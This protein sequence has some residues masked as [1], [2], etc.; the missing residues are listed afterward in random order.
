MPV[1]WWSNFH[2]V[3]FYWLIP[4][5]IRKLLKISSIW[6]AKVLLNSEDQGAKAGTKF[7][8]FRTSTQISLSE[9]FQGVARE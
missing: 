6:A 5:K 1:T 4:Y 7:N 8:F 2:G 9:A 3:N